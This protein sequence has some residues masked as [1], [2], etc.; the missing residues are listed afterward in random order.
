MRN[1]PCLFRGL[2]LDIRARHPVTNLFFG[3]T[4]ELSGAAEACRG[5]P[6]SAF[7]G[8][9][10]GGGIFAVLLRFSVPFSA[11]AEVNEEN[12]NVRRADTADTGRLPDGHRL[13]CI[14]FLCRFQAKTGNVCIVKVVRKR[15]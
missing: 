8:Y 15:P 3:E 12:R 10:R 11:D 7:A 14:Q 6:A 9:S 5:M 13:L 4:E 2:T 1:A